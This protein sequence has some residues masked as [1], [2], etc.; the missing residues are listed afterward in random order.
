VLLGFLDKQLDLAEQIP[1]QLNNMLVGVDRKILPHLA[2]R[3]IR[4]YLNNRLE[5][6]F[7]WMNMQDPLIGGYT[8]EKIALRRAI[9]MAYDRDEDINVHTLGPV[10]AARGLLPPDVPG[11]DPK[12]PQYNRHDVKLANALLDRYGYQKR[13]AEG[14]RLLPDGKKLTLEMH[15][16]A[17]ATGRVYDERWRKA[18][19]SIGI[20][21]VFKSD[22][23]TEI[24]KASRL[25]K[26]QMFEFGWVADYPDASNYY[27]LLYGPNIGISNDARFDLPQYNKLYEESQRLPNGPQRSQLLLQMEQ[28]I[29]AYMPLLVRIH[30]QSV[31]VAQPWLKHYV[32]PPVDNTA[33]RYLDLDLEERARAR[34]VQDFIRAFKVE[35]G[36]AD[37]GYCAHHAALDF[38]HID[39]KQI[40]VC[41]AKSVQQAMAEIARCEVVCANCHRVRTFE[42]LQKR[43][44]KPDIF[45]ATYEPA[46]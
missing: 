23:Y 30:K 15:S 13:D 41:N 44:C 10:L 18:L 37:C 45:D 27:Q 3:N 35:H 43:P 21:I 12:L 17:N 24:I 20:R 16:R 5:T 42:R 31:D 2:A 25:G 19:Q 1:E 22:K 11:Y 8:T 38:D 40:N 33:W 46:E 28:L 7:M 34:K 36:C 39:E 4:L 6:D 29:Q 9:A 32:R 26:V 14:Y